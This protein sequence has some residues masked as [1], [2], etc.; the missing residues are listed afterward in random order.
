MEV[1]SPRLNSMACHTHAAHT[2]GHL[3]TRPCNRA[4]L[5]FRFQCLVLGESRRYL[6]THCSPGELSLRSASL[7]NECP[8]RPP[9][10]PLDR[11]TTMLCKVITTQSFIVE[12][13]ALSISSVLH[14]LHHVCRV[15]G[16]ETKVTHNRAPIHSRHAP[17]T[18]ALGSTHRETLFFYTDFYLQGLGWR[19]W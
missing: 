12:D 6:V 7:G 10:L 17:K 19:T 8:R 18:K 15:Q 16:T 4:F 11:R 9:E 13:C 3:A 1:Q 2:R 14:W 5:S